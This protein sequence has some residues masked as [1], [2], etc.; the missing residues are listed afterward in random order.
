LYEEFFM[1][2]ILG[3]MPL[4]QL[5]TTVGG[6]GTSAGG[7]G[8]VERP[9]A[10]VGAGGGAGAAG[11]GNAVTTAPGSATSTAPGGEGARP[12]PLS[13]LMSFLPI[14]LAMVAL[15]YFLNRGQRK[16]E[17]KRKDMINEMRKGDRVMTIGGLIARV[18]SIEADEVV[19]K[20]DESANV[21]A[22]YSKKSIQ[23]VLDRD[24]KK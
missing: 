20:I 14:I 24:E 10:T 9:A 7:S 1:H 5:N 22:T 21:K 13:G 16:Q 12:S 18:V 11:G 17:K 6:T 8:T 4:A 15:F 19:L 3:L 2:E 23:E